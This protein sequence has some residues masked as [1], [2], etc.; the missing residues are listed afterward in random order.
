[1]Q[2]NKLT[3][4]SIDVDAQK[5]FS[6]LCPDELPVSEAEQIVP[7]L[8]RQAHYARL[9]VGSKDAHSPNA[10]WVATPTEPALTSLSG[11]NVDCY[12][13]VHAV[14]GTP[15]FELLAD[16]PHPKD[17]DF[18]I[19][20]GVEPDMHPYGACYHDLTGKLSTGLIEYLRQQQITTVLVGGLALDYCVKTTALQLVEAG[21]S[22]IINLA[23]T[24]GI[25]EES[26]Y[27]A[28]KELKKN[29]IQFIESTADLQST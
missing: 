23:A 16:L 29:G 2:I 9:R 27:N 10:I 19:W 6:P 1:M 17:Y 13:P 8:N 4:A 25:S 15:G 24:R 3:T 11:E 14:P 21:F 28:I 5:T 12:W 18:F 26:S 7:E 22:V 20:K